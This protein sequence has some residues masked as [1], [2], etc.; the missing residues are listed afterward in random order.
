MYSLVRRLRAAWR[1]RR[2]RGML[3]N[4]LAL[5][6]RGEAR[7]DGLSLLEVSFKLTVNWRARDI[8]PWDR[9]LPEV[10]AAPRLLDQTLQDAEAAVERIFSAFPEANTLE[11]NVF[12][13]DPASNRVIMSGLVARSDLKRCASSSIAMR[14]RMLGINYCVA[15]QRLEPIATGTPPS[16]A[17][18]ISSDAADL[19]WPV[20][21][22]RQPTDLAAKSR[23]RWPDGEQGQ[24]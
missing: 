6:R 8:H 17:I 16:P 23:P 1:L 4:A 12:E 21:R 5:H 2:T 19:R 10:Q 14:L 11:L 22:V 15:N 9:D 18:D 24:H 13:K 3:V 20:A 7:S